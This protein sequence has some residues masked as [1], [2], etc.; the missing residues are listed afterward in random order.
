MAALTKGM[1]YRRQGSSGLIWADNMVLT[2]EGIFAMNRVQNDKG[3]SR[4]DGTTGEAQPGVN[5]T[6]SK[7]VGSASSSISV[8]APTSRHKSSFSVFKWLKKAI[9]KIRR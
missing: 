2:E 7:S 3:Y 8:V 4:T 5:M 1:S 6:R 9:T